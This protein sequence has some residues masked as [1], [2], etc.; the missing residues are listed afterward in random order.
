MDKFQYV[1]VEN[2]LAKYTR[3]FRNLEVS[4]TDAIEWIGEAL[5][6]MKLA[7]ALEEA[8]AFLEV[9]NYEAALPNGLHYIIQIARNTEWEEAQPEENLSTRKIVNCVTLCDD[10]T[11]VS[12]TNS[13]GVVTDC[14]GNPIHFDG[15]YKS[16]YRPYFDLQWEYHLWRQSDYFREKWEAVRLANH[17]FFNSIVCQDPNDADIYR[18]QHHY[19]EYTIAGDIL[20]FSFETG[21]VAVAYLRQKTDPATGYPMIPDDEYAR[22]AV[23]YYLAWKIKQREAYL[24]REGALT[25]AKDAQEQWNS[26]IKKF[27]NKAKMPHGLDQYQNLAEQ[28]RYLIPRHNRYYGF[29]GK[30]GRLEDRPFNHPEGRYRTFIG[31]SYYG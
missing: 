19:E 17:S 25:L 24:H 30:L 29:F 1:T 12:N 13:C 28:S 10:S 21:Y 16:Y 15:D 6:F 14:N 8:I 5:G 26:Y 22:N 4:E 23:T 7:T 11:P 2:I 20:R 31:N 3:D 9:K 18:N 27:K